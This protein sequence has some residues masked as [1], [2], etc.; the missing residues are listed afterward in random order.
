[1]LVTLSSAVNAT[2]IK[3]RM[4][5]TQLTF[6]IVGSNAIRI[7]KTRQE[8]ETQFSNASYDGIE[9]L[10][11][12]PPLAV[13]WAGDLWAIAVTIPAQVAVI[14]NTDDSSE[15]GFFFDVSTG[16]R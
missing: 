1:V 3:T 6:R 11:S 10:P 2:K 14:E 4:R 13:W 12:D 9:L 16:R 7:G 15:T 5:R 8:C